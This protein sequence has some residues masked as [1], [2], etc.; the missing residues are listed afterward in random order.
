[1]D[2]TAELRRL[3]TDLREHDAVED[4]WLAKSFTDRLLVVDLRTGSVPAEIRERLE[5]HDCYGAND[6][7]ETGEA[8]ASF[9][10][11][12]GDETRHQF[13]DV[14]TRGDHQSYVVE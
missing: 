6:V 4:A 10:G 3:A 2:R 5:E 11:S 8:D 7:Y 1:M 9:A 13:V 12:V 14:Q